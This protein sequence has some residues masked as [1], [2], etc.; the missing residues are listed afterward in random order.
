MMPIERLSWHHG[1][2][3]QR[4]ECSGTTDGRFPTKG[5]RGQT[6]TLRAGQKQKQ[7]QVHPGRIDGTSSVE[8]VLVGDAPS[9]PAKSQT[10]AAQSKPAHPLWAPLSSLLE[11][12]WKHSCGRFVT[13]SILMKKD[14]LQ[15][16]QV[17][18]D[19]PMLGCATRLEGVTGLPCE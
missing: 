7:K 1:E 11:S 6:G 16:I 15:D 12:R 13:D 5:R 19:S 9:Q 14:N 10:E 2:L 3:I 17:L 8:K 4:Q 18:D